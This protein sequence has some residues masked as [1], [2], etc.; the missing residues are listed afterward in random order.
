MENKDF[1]KLNIRMLS[2]ATSV[3]GQGVGSAYLE[4][5]ALV[6]E[7]DDL[8]NVFD[9]K[10][11][12]KTKVDINH[13]H[14]VMPNFY[15]KMTKSVCNVIYVHFLP[16][17]LDGSI[18]LSKFVFDIFKKY[19]VSMYKKADEVVVVNPIFIQPLV[20]LGLKEENITYIPNYVSKEQFY[21]LDKE[22]I[23]ETRKSYGFSDED[24]IVLG[25]GQIQTRKGVKDFVEV[26]KMNPNIQF[27]WAGGFSFGKITDVYK[28]LKE[29]VDNPPANVHFIGLVERTKMN[30]IFNMADILF[31]PSFTELF[32]M[33][34]LE[35]VNSEKPVLLRD[36]DLYE[37]ILFKKYEKASDVEGFSNV[38]NQLKNDKEYYNNASL[39]SKFISEYYS[40][41]NVAKLWREYYPRIYQK[42]LDRKAAKK[43]KKAKKVD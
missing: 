41:E 15:L 20:K 8:F 31:M 9:N 6:K 16:T 21:K 26:A 40:K 12:L 1:R 24:F 23:S 27:V 4:Q 5:V 32:P 42:Y 39:N 25:C 43:A 10:V 28:E 19:V 17:T 37:N 30:N 33:A 13:V 3:D 7:Q 34:I 35:A 2:N 14:T 38:I 22:T 11:P 36:V 18:K 29:I